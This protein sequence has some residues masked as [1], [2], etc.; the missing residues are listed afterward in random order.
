L[1][2]VLTSTTIEIEHEQRTAA[3]RAASAALAH[4]LECRLRAVYFRP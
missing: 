2:A 3:V 4:R 1:S